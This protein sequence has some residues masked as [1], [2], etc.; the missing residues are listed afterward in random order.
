MLAH[1]R[2]SD[3]AAQSLAE[4]SR[5][6]QYLCRK[7]AEH[8]GLGNAASL[9]GLLHDMGKAC[10]EFARY[11]TDSYNGKTPSVH[12]LHAATGAF[13]A[14]KRWFNPK[15][16]KP[17]RLCAQTVAMCILGHHTGLCNVLDFSGKFE[18]RDKLT[19]RMPDNFKDTSSWFFENIASAE[20]LDR[21]FEK[22]CDEFEA[23]MPE[24]KAF[25]A[26]LLMRLLLGILVDSD[27]YDSA[28]FEYGVDSLSSDASEPD[29]HRLFET[30]EAFR[31]SRLNGDSPINRIR[32]EIS[33]VCLK[34]AKKR[35]KIVTLTVPTGG[36]KTFLTLRYALKYAETFDCERIFYIIPY[37]TILDQNSRDIRKALDDYDGI[38]EHHSNVVIEDENELRDYTRLTERWDSTII[39]T[40]L[41][42]F[43]DSCYK[44]KNSDARRFPRLA[45]SVLIFDEIQSLPKKCKA[46]FENA[47]H[48][49][50]EYCGAQVVLCTATQ[51]NLK[52]GE[53]RIIEELM[54]NTSELFARLERVRYST[55]INIPRTNEAAAVELANILERKS[56]LAVVNT[57]IAASDIYT[58]VKQLL[59]ERGLRTI[60]P[61][62]SISDDNIEAFASELDG[63][64]ILC[65]HL[66]TLLCPAH[67]LALI[68]WIKTFTRL[69]RRVFCISTA[70]I[71]AG[72]NLSFPVVVRSLAGL[73][74]IVQAAGRCNRNMEAEFGEVRIWDLI[75]ENLDRLDEI[76]IG[77][78]CTRAIVSNNEYER[79]FDHPETVKR[80]F[81][82][83]QQQTEGLW[84]FPLKGKNTT[85]VDLLGKNERRT[86]AFLERYD[87]DAL[88][89]RVIALQGFRDA[90]E[91]FEVIPDN[92]KSILVSFGEGS[93]I[94]AELSGS[95]SPRERRLLLKKAQA[96]SV[97]VYENT[98]ERLSREGALCMLG[99]SGVVVLR[100][101]YYSNEVGVSVERGEMELMEF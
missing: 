54:P 14:Y 64:T 55:E 74:S 98:Y 7:S 35:S 18:L 57:K 8:L 11:L 22:A 101:G 83:E 19:D 56:V 5:N 36:G 63:E 27:R 89:S 3:G 78:K 96:Y 25:N 44:G 84:D 40:S 12:P 1:I 9:I 95:H 38:L 34:S 43:L 81:V 65:V 99:D 31:L 76:Q 92:T 37:N 47:I 61:D 49:L 29:W 69:G 24:Y 80:Y 45:N 90:G 58:S 52:F 87:A 68:E 16:S 82:R 50:T 79:G 72:V 75:D 28:C 77:Q 51:P 6:V 33:D 21:L 73:T 85:L 15:A 39:L 66:T 42:R 2:S 59:E 97:S 71:E 30:F 4:H 17:A 13:F 88:R 70:L 100:E 91:A 20:E 60:I 67:R 46:L 94:I 10:D 93:R 23:F 48:F 62:C 86:A 53:G 41:V 26:G 32:S